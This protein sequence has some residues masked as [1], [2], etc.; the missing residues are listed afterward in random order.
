[1][2]KI[3]SHRTDFHKILISEHFSKMCVRKSDKNNG[4]FTCRLIYI[5][6]YEFFLE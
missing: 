2:K 5:Y 3:G 1:M 4:Y 6:L